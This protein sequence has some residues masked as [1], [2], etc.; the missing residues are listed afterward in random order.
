MNN[1]SKIKDRV[2][3]GMSTMVYI[4]SNKELWGISETLVTDDGMGMCTVS[5]YRHNPKGAWISNLGV[6]HT[7]R[8]KGLGRNLL[9]L[10][11]ERAKERGAD[12]VSLMVAPGKRWTI[13]WYIRE[14]FKPQPQD[15]DED[16]YIVM[17]KKIE[18]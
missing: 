18:R 6:F 9:D 13:D 16:G 8:R 15:V 1:N 7:A 17:T 5:I 12:Q 3:L 14:G 4:H 11:I 2:P 10:A